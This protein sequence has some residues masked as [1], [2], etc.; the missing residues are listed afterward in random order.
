MATRKRNPPKRQSQTAVNRRV[1]KK[2]PPPVATYEPTDLEEQEDLDF[3]PATPEL[4]AKLGFDPDEEWPAD[5][6]FWE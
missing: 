5:P 4:I 3:Q 6:E 2:E 1:P